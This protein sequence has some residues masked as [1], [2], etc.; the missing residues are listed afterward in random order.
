MSF[1]VN[2]VDFNGTNEE[3]GKTGASFSLGANTIELW[4]K[5]TDIVPAGEPRHLAF[6]DGSSN[7]LMYIE[8][9]LGKIYCIY[10]V[11]GASGL[12]NPSSPAPS[13]GSIMHIIIAHNGTNA[14]KLVVN[15]SVVSSAFTGVNSLSGTVTQIFMGSGGGAKYSPSQIACGSYWN[16]YL[17]DA[18]CIALYDSGNGYKS[19]K[20]NSLGNYTSTSAL[21]QQWSPGI[22]GTSVTTM[23]QSYVSS[24]GLNIGDNAS[25]ISSADIV[26]WA[27]QAWSQT[28][29]ETLSLTASIVN[30]GGKILSDVLSLTD[31]ILTATGK[32][33]VLT[34]T[35]SMV[36]SVIKTT[37]KAFS[38]TVSLVDSKISTISRSLSDTMSFISSID[39]L[40]TM[41]V[42]LS[43]ILSLVEST[44]QKTFSKFLSEVTNLAAFSSETT[45][46]LFSDSLSLSDSIK[47]ATSKILS[48]AFSLSDRIKEYLNGILVTW[49]KIFS[50]RSSSWGDKFSSKSTSWID[51]NP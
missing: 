16:S 24:G 46:R 41:N 13:N 35:I 1:N 40:K 25:N 42:V 19:D 44:I 8:F 12:A 37:G 47:K 7:N 18:E 3:M 17:S 15:G 27:A 30:T 50:S 33:I 28:C 20:R 34:S 38:E 31:S 14:A 29:S 32:S 26:A 36:E 9:Y 21:V 48:D 2:A 6:K 43:D 10:G 23:G 45:S 11:G 49:S 39:T 5:P 22:D 51:K 4:I